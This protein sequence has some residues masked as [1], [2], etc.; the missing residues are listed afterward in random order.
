M[1]YKYKRDGKTVKGE[2]ISSWKK[3][4]YGR[5]IFIIDA[6]EAYET[7]IIEVG[8]G[9]FMSYPEVGAGAV[10]WKESGVAMRFVRFM[11]DG[12]HTAE[13]GTIY[14]VEGKRIVNVNTTTPDYKRDM[15]VYQALTGLSIAEIEQILQ[16][17][18]P[19]HS[20][21]DTAQ[22]ALCYQA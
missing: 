14:E 17:C 21:R 22:A 16:A 10:V 18:Q 3:L 20:Q 12:K 8:E 2:I 9:E 19:V 13:D 7:E 5:Y 15:L 6:L 11:Q 4:P 1:K